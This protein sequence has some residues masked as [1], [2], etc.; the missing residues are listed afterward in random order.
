ML[1]NCHYC[2]TT[3]QPVPPTLDE[4]I[5]HPALRFC[6]F[7]FQ[8]YGRLVTYLPVT[9]TTDTWN[10]PDTDSYYSDSDYEV[11]S[12]DDEADHKVRAFRAQQF[13][14]IQPSGA[15]GVCLEEFQKEQ[16]YRQLPCQHNFHESCISSW[17]AEKDTCP[18]CRGK[19]SSLQSVN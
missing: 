18:L 13:S 2:F 3:F 4:L 8:H 1:V 17:F 11:I 19:C 12:S 9:Q 6:P 15:C 16:L 5:W 7:C 10:L 14:F